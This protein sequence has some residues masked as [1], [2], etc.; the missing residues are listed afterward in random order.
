MSNLNLQDYLLRSQRRRT[1]PLEVVVLHDGFRARKRVEGLLL[2]MSGG[3]GPGLRLICAY[4]RIGEPFGDQGTTRSPLI[5]LV[6]LA[7]SCSATLP[8]ETLA[9]VTAWLPALKA[10][11]GALAFLS[12]ANVPRQLDVAMIER[13]LC[14]QSERA[15]VAFFSGCMPGL[16]CPGCGSPKLG[17][18]ARLRAEQLC[19]LHAPENSRPTTHPAAARKAESN[20]LKR[21]P[22]TPATSGHPARVA[23]KRQLRYER[24]GQRPR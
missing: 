22:V 4:Q 11:H 12:G 16:G 5:R 20:K 6:F 10:N 21:L 15:G 2:R 8:P 1:K 3:F 14:A 19:V 7:A 24:P 18:R 17:E 13:F 23:A 9:S